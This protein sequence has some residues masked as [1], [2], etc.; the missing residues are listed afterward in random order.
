MLFVLFYLRLLCGGHLE[1]NRRPQFYCLKLEDRISFGPEWLGIFKG[2][3][4][5]SEEALAIEDTGSIYKVC[6]NYY[7]SLNYANVE[8]APRKL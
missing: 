7:M 5:R 1:S 4:P 3:E 8:E 2:K 6:L